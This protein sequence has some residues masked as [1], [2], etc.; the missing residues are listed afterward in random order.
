MGTLSTSSSEDSPDHKGDC[1]ATPNL[2]SFTSFIRPKIAPITKGIATARMQVSRRLLIQ[3]ED[4]PDHK[5]DCDLSSSYT[6]MTYP[7][8]PKIAPITKGIA[9][10]C[11]DELVAVGVESEDSPDHKGDCDEF[12]YPGLLFLL[13]VRR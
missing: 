6:F 7:P 1:D 13:L 10:P 9:T 3:S 2:P 4:S 11:L 5:G 12:I 8:S